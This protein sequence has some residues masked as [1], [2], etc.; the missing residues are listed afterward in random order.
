[1]SVWRL[2]R[3]VP[4]VGLAQ[5]VLGREHQRAGRAHRDAVAAVHAGRLGQRIGELGRDP[6]VES[7]PRD[8]DRERVLPLLAAGVDALVTEDALGVVAH[9]EVVVDLDRRVHRGGRLA[10][11]LLVVT[12]PLAVAVGVRRRRRA[13]ARR[14][15][16]VARRGNRRRRGSSRGRSR[17]PGTPSPSCGCGG[18]ARS[19][20]ARPCRPR[21]GASTRAP[22]LARPRARRRRRGRRSPAAASRR[23]R[24]SAC[25]CPAARRRRGSSR[26][27]APRPAGRR[28]S[29]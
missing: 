27:P 4:V 19:R 26:P 14:V 3:L 16:V 9:V 21:R 10:V 7:A 20:C 8:G 2:A 25:R 11:G 24:A 12:R 1:M 22:G 23:S 18:P 5:L 13:V 28:S 6:C 29:A 17:R 15:R